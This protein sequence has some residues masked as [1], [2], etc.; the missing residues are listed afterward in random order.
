M[1]DRAIP[2]HSHIQPLL[3]AVALG[4]RRHQMMSDKVGS[5]PSYADPS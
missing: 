5:D 1:A 2:G 4:A 3:P